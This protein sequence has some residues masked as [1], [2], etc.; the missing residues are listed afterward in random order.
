MMIEGDI[1]KITYKELLIIF[2][3][4]NNG[5]A[6]WLRLIYLKGGWSTSLAPL[7]KLWSFQIKIVIVVNDKLQRL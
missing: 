6:L 5:V 7:E 4:T 2:G 1:L 3:M